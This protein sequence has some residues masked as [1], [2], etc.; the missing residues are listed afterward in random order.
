MKEQCHVDF[1]YK[2]DQSQ[3]AHLL[4]KNMTHTVDVHEKRSE[5]SLCKMK[6]YENLSFHTALLTWPQVT[7]PF[8]V[9]R[10]LSQHSS[11]STRLGL[12]DIASPR[13]LSIYLQHKRFNIK[14]TLRHVHVCIQATDRGH[15]FSL[16]RQLFLASCMTR[17]W[18]QCIAFSWHMRSWMNQLI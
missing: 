10:S 9:S 8:T 18:L 11:K 17:C 5:V 12:S 15:D 3:T 13:C 4:W 14:F 7:T 1:F 2:H 6:G 16:K